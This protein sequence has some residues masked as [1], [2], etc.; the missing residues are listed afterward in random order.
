MNFNN[1]ILK[2][3]KTLIKAFRNG[4]IARK[5]TNHTIFQASDSLEIYE[6]FGEY[7]R[8]CLSNPQTKKSLNKMF[9][10]IG[11]CDGAVDSISAIAHHLGVLAENT[12]PLKK[13]FIEAAVELRGAYQE[14]AEQFIERAEAITKDICERQDEVTQEIDEEV[15]PEEVK[16]A[17]EAAAKAAEAAEKAAKEAAEKAAEEEA[18]K[19]AEEEEAKK[20]ERKAKNKARR[21]NT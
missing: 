12:E 10:S 21:C 16:A 20:A 9:K 5:L 6:H 17:K 11:E 13:A 15:F 14:D 2:K 8:N 7:L 18:T 19:K 4:V 3:T 1:T